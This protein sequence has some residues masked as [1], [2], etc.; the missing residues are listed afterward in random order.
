[1]REG[2]VRLFNLHLSLTVPVEISG[3]KGDRGTIWVSL[4]LLFSLL[5]DL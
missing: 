1:M 4:F 5:L 2:R 3:D